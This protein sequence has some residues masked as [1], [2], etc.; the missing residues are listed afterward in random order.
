[1][2]ANSVPLVTVAAAVSAPT[3]APQ[4]A[5]LRATIADTVASPAGT[6]AGLS[7]G[8]GHNKQSFP[9]EANVADVTSHLRAH[10]NPG[11]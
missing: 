10:K 2:L 9:A 4:C 7:L 11:Q 5:R 6:A 8:G 1:M 3:G